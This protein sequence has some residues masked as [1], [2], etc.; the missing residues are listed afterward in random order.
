[1]VDN[2]GVKYIDKA[3]SDHLLDALKIHYEISVDCTGG[4][5][6]VITLK[7]RY[8]N[9]IKKHYVEISVTGYVTKQLQKYQHEISKRPQHAPYPSTPNK[10]GAAPQEPI[11]TDYSKPELSNGINFVH[12]IVDS[13]LYY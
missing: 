9:E 7:W 3:D 4:L 6:Y 13:I 11:K 12:K 8:N 2:V 1:M 5:Y 10:Y